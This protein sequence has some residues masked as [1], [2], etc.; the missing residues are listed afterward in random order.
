MAAASAIEQVGGPRIITLYG[1]Q[2]ADQA[3]TQ[4]GVHVP[5][6]DQAMLGEGGGAPEEEEQAE[7]PQ[8]G[9][10]PPIKKGK[11]EKALERLGLSTRQMA[12]V[13][14][15]TVVGWH[16]VEALAH[17]GKWD[18]SYF[19][20]VLEDVKARLK[21]KADDAEDDAEPPPLAPDRAMVMSDRF[22]EIVKSYAEDHS[23]AT[24]GDDYME[25]H[26][27]MSEAGA[28]FDPRAPEGFFLG[29]SSTV[30][31]AMT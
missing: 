17:A 31:A 18:V 5:V 30:P 19:T 28:V 21:K 4:E 8:E 3:F 15:S 20:H 25:V 1:R 22:L 10:A 7:E 2:D 9:E 24:F 26:K 12:A 13:C 27:I 14:G 29:V 6:I 23:G 16:K 11:L